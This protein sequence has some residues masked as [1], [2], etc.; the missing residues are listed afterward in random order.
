MCQTCVD[1]GRLS[2]AT[3]DM[4]EDFVYQ[5]PDSEFGPAHIVLGD[6]NVEDSHLTWCLGLCWAALTKDPKYLTRDGDIEFMDRME[7]Y[8]HENLYTLVATIN[9]LEKLL[10]IPEEER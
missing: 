5:Y 2:Q 4:I 7:W 6:D 3:F 8:P 9:F 1:E 10:T